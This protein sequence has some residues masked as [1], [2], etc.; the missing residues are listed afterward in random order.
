VVSI[1]RQLIG[2]GAIFSADFTH[3]LSCERPFNFPRHHLLQPLGIDNKVTISDV[4]IHSAIF[5]FTRHGYR[6]EHGNDMDKDTDKDTDKD[7]DT[8]KDTDMDMEFEYFCEISIQRKS[9]YCTVLIS[10][11]TSG[12]KFR[13]HYKFVPDENYRHE[14]FQKVIPPLKLLYK[15]C[16]SRIGNISKGLKKGC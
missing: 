12:R 9:H 7:M 4:N 5:K 1:D 3:P 16:V 14:Y 11:D 8:E 15:Q 2:S 10:C 6:Q 13:R